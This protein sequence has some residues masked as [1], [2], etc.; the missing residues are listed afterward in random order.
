MHY[1]GP[2]WRPSYGVCPRLHSAN[3]ADQY[4]PCFGP[5]VTYAAFP[6]SS[7]LQRGRRA[8]IRPMRPGDAP[9]SSPTGALFPP[10]DADAMPRSARF[11][12]GLWA[13]RREP[14]GRFAASPMQSAD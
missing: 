12:G 7:E 2:R 9:T 10:G 4:A 8:F 13:L 14:Q 11:F 1:Y 5:G 6:A 3:S